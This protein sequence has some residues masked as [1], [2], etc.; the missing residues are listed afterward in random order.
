M[1]NVEWLPITPGTDAALAAIC[2]WELIQKNAVDLD[3]LH[4][5]RVGFDEAT[6]PEAFRGKAHVVSRL[7][8]GRRAMTASRKTP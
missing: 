7:R 8:D 4:A 1:G 2:V 6:M 5:Y 3:F